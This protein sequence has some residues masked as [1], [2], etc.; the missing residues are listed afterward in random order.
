MKLYCA[1]YKDGTEDKA[2][3]WL[4]Q[5]DKKKVA[6]TIDRI[7]VEGLPSEYYVWSGASWAPGPKPVPVNAR[8]AALRE[9]R[10]KAGLT[11]LEVWAHP[12]DHHAI[13]DEAARLAKARDAAANAE[14][15]R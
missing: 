1:R 2:L 13:R 5:W 11:R 15:S 3:P 7:E 10:H 14:V 12:D 4:R 6:E 9:R 8:V